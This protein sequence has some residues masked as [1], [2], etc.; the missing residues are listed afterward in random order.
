[1]WMLLLHEKWW[2]FFCRR[3]KRLVCRC[4]H[5]TRRKMGIIIV[6]FFVSSRESFAVSNSSRKQMTSSL[7]TIKPLRAKNLFPSRFNLLSFYGNSHLETQYKHDQSVETFHVRIFDVS[8]E[9]IFFPPRKKN[10]GG[11]GS[12]KSRTLSTLELALK[13]LDHDRIILPGN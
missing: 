13:R 3:P 2:A 9:R 1:M 12:F 8:L 11:K 7:N 6:F 5:E 10:V 4:L